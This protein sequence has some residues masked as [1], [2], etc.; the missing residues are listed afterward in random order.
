MSYIKVNNPYYHCKKITSMRIFIN[1]KIEGKAKESECWSI[2]SKNYQE[3]KNALSHIRPEI[4]IENEIGKIY[5]KILAGKQKRSF[6]YS[7]LNKLIYNNE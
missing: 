1:W 7:G 6:I 2:D 4:K 3:S 5:D